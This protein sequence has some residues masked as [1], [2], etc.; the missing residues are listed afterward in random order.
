MSTRGPND[1]APRQNAEPERDGNAETKPAVRGRPFAKGNPGRP[2]GKRRPRAERWLRDLERA[3]ADPRATPRDRTYATDLLLRYAAKPDA[4]RF[5]ASCGEDMGDRVHA[6]RVF[7]INPDGS[8]ARPVQEPQQQ[9]ATARPAPQQAEDDDA[10]LTTA[11]TLE[12]RAWCKQFLE[13]T[14]EYAE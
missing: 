9:A 6:I 10:P 5:C 13:D 11:E 14:R 1:A 3:A 2:P 7:L 8:V 12:L 4:E